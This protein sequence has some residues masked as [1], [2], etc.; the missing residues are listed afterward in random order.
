MYHKEAYRAVS[1][2]TM[3]MD[4]FVSWLKHQKGQSYREGYKEGYK[5]GL[6]ESDF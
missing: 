2:G 3:S 6:Y 1:D 5:D 4:E